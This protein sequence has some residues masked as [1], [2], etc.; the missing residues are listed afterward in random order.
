M[1]RAM[2]R[3]ACPAG[4]PWCGLYPLRPIGT[5]LDRYKKLF[6]HPD[7]LRKKGIST[8][9]IDLVADNKS[10]LDVFYRRIKDVT[11]EFKILPE[12]SVIY[13]KRLRK[14]GESALDLKKKDEVAACIRARDNYPEVDFVLPRRTAFTMKRF[15]SP[16]ARQYIIRFLEGEEDEIMC[17]M[18]SLAFHKSKGDCVHEFGSRGL[19]PE[20][21]LPAL[22]SGRAQSDRAAHR[23]YQLQL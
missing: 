16:H 15:P 3:F 21:L 22:H 1:L 14:S 9:H 6:I 4:L 20:D 17:T 13:A 18:Q 5:G 19:A 11:T 8:D 23:A 7:E 10:S 12:R 2:A